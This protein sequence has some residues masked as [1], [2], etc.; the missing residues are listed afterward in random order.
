MAKISENLKNILE[1]TSK[2]DLIKIIIRFAKK[3]SEMNQ[4]L[5]Y[6]LVQANTDCE[7]YDDLLYCIQFEMSDIDGKIIQKELAKAISKCISEINDFTK[8]TKS[9]YNEALALQELLNI[10]FEKYKNDLG[11]CF[12]VFDSKVVS[13]AIRYF[14]LVIKL[15]EDYHVEFIEN[16]ERILIHVK[17][18]CRHYDSVFVLPQS[19]NG[20]IDK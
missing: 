12:T 3:N 18:S 1:K 2:E 4:I 15:H 17:N 6:E 8:I 5:E 14:N 13:T 7:L 20:F 19:F 9:K 16:F 10:I 11:T